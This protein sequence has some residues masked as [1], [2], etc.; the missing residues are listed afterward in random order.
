VTAWTV[1]HP[2]PLSMGFPGKNTGVG[3]CA[4]L[5]GIFL[6]QETNS[7]F[8]HCRKILYYLSH[9]GIWDTLAVVRTLQC[10]C[11]DYKERS[12]YPSVAG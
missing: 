10:S 2:A 9:Q 1:A 3:C 12:F 11:T 4:L 7:G 8:L 6:T 5:Q